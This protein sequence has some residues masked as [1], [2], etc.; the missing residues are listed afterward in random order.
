MNPSLSPAIVALS[1][2]AATAQDASSFTGR[3]NEPGWFVEITGDM[4]S[5]TRQ[6]G[7]GVESYPAPA[8][9]TVGDARRYAVPDGPTVTV[10]NTL[11][12]D[13]ATGMPYPAQVTVQVEGSTLAGRGGASLALLTG[14]DWRVTEIGGAAVP[15][16]TDAYFGFSAEGQIA[17]KSAC[18]RFTG[19]TELTGEGLSVGPLAG[20]RMACP[21]PAGAT[22]AAFLPA[23]AQ[24]DRI[25]IAEDGGLRLM[26]GHEVA[27]ADLR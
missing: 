9:E 3:G 18:N 16:G 6:G 2:G 24:V 13:S 11:C 22:E 1:A 27:I 21:D 25:D 7:K 20:T 19:R 12:R 4:L 17:G 10:A 23:I 14:D 8:P 15:S 5:L 26:G